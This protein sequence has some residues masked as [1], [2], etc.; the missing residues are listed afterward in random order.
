[1]GGRPGR[2]WAGPGAAVAL[3]AVLAVVS[4][5]SL[6]RAPDGLW[7]KGPGPDDWA[8]VSP[9]SQLAGVILDNNGVVVATEPGSPLSD[10]PARYPDDGR[11]TTCARSAHV[12][13]CVH[14]AFGRRLADR[15]AAAM[16]PVAARAAGIPEAPARVRTVP[17]TAGF[18]SVCHR[19]ELL[20]SEESARFVAVGADGVRNDY[21]GCLFD[22][23]A[24]FGSAAEAVLLWLVGLDGQ[25]AD[26]TGYPALAAAQAMARLP[27]AQVQA[28]LR[29]DWAR[30]RDGSLKLA[31]LPGQRP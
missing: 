4:A 24:E 1:V 20:L 3:G 27:E 2:A 8:P 26:A 16:E 7:F 25:P 6:V 9:D 10:Q 28:A 19:G 29:R 12:Q 18:G 13:V 15:L 31:E 14:P 17:T 11:A 30:I 5:G 21:A 23:N 22:D